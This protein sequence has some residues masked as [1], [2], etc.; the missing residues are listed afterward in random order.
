MTVKK[1]RKIVRHKQTVLMAV[2]KADLDTLIIPPRLSL[3]A[4]KES[5]ATMTDWFNVTF[6]IKVG[7][8]IAEKAYQLQTEEGMRLAIIACLKIRDRKRDTNLLSITPYELADIE[9]GLDAVDA[10]QY[11]NIRKLLLAAHTEAKKYVH[12]LL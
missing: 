12:Q 8:Y 10:M 5:K 2:P 6:R 3:A 4:F 11:E 9:M 1:P 7:L